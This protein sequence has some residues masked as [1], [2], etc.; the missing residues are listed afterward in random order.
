MSDGA[1]QWAGCF[2]IVGRRYQDLVMIININKINRKIFMKLFKLLPI[3]CLLALFQSYGMESEY[4]ETYN[5]KRQRLMPSANAELKLP[6][7]MEGLVV[8]KS[9]LEHH[10]VEESKDTVM[11]VDTAIAAHNPAQQ[12]I[13]RGEVE[14]QPSEAKEGIIVKDHRSEPLFKLLYDMI[15]T[16]PPELINLILDYAK[17]AGKH[18]RTIDGENLFLTRNLITLSQHIIATRNCLGKIVVWDLET[19]KQLKIIADAQFNS[20]MFSESEFAFKGIN[21]IA[22]VNWQTDSTRTISTDCNCFNYVA[23]LPHGPL[24]TYNHETKIIK[25]WD[26]NTGRLIQKMALKKHIHAVWPISEHIIATKELCRI[27]LWDIDTGKEITT[28]TL[29]SHPQKLIPLS[30]TIIAIATEETIEIYDIT[31]SRLSRMIGS[32]IRGWFVAKLIC[33]IKLQGNLIDVTK[34][35][36]ENIIVAAIGNENKMTIELYDPETGYCLKNFETGLKAENYFS[37]GKIDCPSD[38]CIVAIGE[39]LQSG[40]EE[41]KIWN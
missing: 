23:K 7:A 12:L 41:I 5:P 28:I 1:F 3:L 9:A 15:T 21:S 38:S 14:G 22:I 35:P 36:T 13:I 39:G 18:V 37:E 8:S 2:R 24:M 31:I 32:I 17:F 16:M 29:N 19:G 25:L 6:T 40:K 26:H 20:I 4:K 34:F 10:S 30:A 11:E 33:T 27:T